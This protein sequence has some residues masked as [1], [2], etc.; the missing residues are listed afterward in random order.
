MVIFIFLGVVSSIFQLVV[1][2]EFTFS[3]AK[4][5]LSF[6]VACG[7]W[8]I[9]CSLG[10]LIGRR[11]KNSDTAYLPLFFTL[12]F[13]LSVASI[14]LAKS[15]A[16]P[17][18]YEASSLIFVF[19]SSFFLIGILSF[20]VGYAFAVLSKAYLEAHRHTRKTFSRFFAYEALGFFIGGL[21]F[22]FSLSNYSNPFLF[23]FLPLLFFMR[24]PSG[25]KKI[26][27]AALV[28][29]FS[30]VFV[31]GFRP[32][33]KKE[34]KDA[35]IL[36]LKGSHYGPLILAEKFGVKSLYVNGSLAATSEDTAWDEEFIHMSLSAGDRIKDVLFVGPCFSGQLLEILK[37]DINRLDCLDINPALSEF[38]RGRISQ[39]NSRRVRFFIEDP[40]THIRN[41]VKK[42]DCII[43]NMP[44]PSSLAL[45][46][47][48]SYEFFNIIKK[49]LNPGG[50]FCFHIPSKRDILSPHILKF[51]SCIVNTLKGV[52]KKR[53]FIPSDSMI[54]IASDSMSLKPEDL[55]RNFS[56]NNVKTEYFTVYHL[57]DYL[58]PSRRDY[59][60][61]MIDSS[62]E[63][64]RDLNPRGFLY[65]SLLEQA[66]FY[67]GLS[68]NIRKARSALM[69][70]FIAMAITICLLCFL[71]RKPAPLLNVAIVGFS[72]IGLMTILFFIF[73]I[74]LG[75]LFWKMGILVGTF[76]M[77]LAAGTFFVNSVIRKILNKRILAYFYLL[78]VVFTFSLFSSAKGNIFYSDYTF[79][80]YSFILGIL[81]GSVYPLAAG[82]ILKDKAASRNISIPIYAADLSGAFLGTFIFSIFLIPFLG[83]IPTLVILLVSFLFYGLG[84]AFG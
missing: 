48:F 7:I 3:I 42:Y 19:V 61:G 54:I 72:S 46:R 9:F 69:G 53:L 71:K 25:R 67:P 32:I 17:G 80:I 65:Y 64:N 70:A 6:V 47:Y 73:Q 51:D 13:C 16:G 78:W 33:L 50:I 76:M 45:N 24:M 83:I 29:L 44:A 4:N 14:H 81:T 21:A 82:L 58:D 27:P 22:A 31:L 39:N 84:N 8:F 10:S 56:E 68:I 74:Y 77:G 11:N 18:Y 79:Y 59:V 15:L 60:E 5:E 12:S 37:Y 30:I 63:I 62:I 2:R 35:D 57:K 75:S 34:L 40:R 28:I 49:R 20:F 26:L 41:S 38:S 43:M 1:L 23:S 52:F 36:M 55:I 66:K